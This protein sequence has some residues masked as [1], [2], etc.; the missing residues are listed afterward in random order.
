MLFELA[1]RQR[2]SRFP[3]Q[4]PAPLLIIGMYNKLVKTLGT[5]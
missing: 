4:W 3:A 2:E 1:G 5:R